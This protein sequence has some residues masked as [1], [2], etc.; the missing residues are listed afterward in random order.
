V[1]HGQELRV[2]DFLPNEP[3]LEMIIRYDG[4]NTGVITVNNAG[5]VKYTWNLNSSPN[6]TG[7]EAVYWNG[8]DGT[9]LL[10]NGGELWNGD[11]SKHSDLPELPSPIGDEKMGWY[12]CIPADVTGDKREEVVLYNPWDKHIYIYTPFPL[13]ESA[14]E[15]Y[16]PGPRQYNVRLMD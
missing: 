15:G 6:E 13:D 12:H 14:F 11:G 3:G 4:H 7:M 16:D 9:D 8:P 1:P 2:G 5:E 10:Y